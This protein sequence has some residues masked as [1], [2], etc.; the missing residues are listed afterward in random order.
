MIKK[1]IICSHR[2][3]NPPAIT[4]VRLLR[5]A[6][7]EN[8]QWRVAETAINAVAQQ[9]ATLRVSAVAGLLTIGL[10]A[11]PGIRL[12]LP[13]VHRPQAAMISQPEFVS[14]KSADR[15]PSLGDGFTTSAVRQRL[16]AGPE[17]DP[18]NEAP[19]VSRAPALIG[20]V[21]AATLR[22]D[23][24]LVR[25]AGLSLP[26]PGA[27]CKRL[28][29]LAVTCA[30]RA[31]GYLELLVKGRA[32]ACDHLGKAADGIDLSRCRIGETD[33]AEQMIRQG[34]ASA[35]HAEDARLTRAEAA[36]RQQNLG[37]WR[38]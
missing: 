31:T 10:F 16:R 21:D 30:E 27:M 6:F 17:T 23:D 32:V 11:G 8:G 4:G 25:V 24:R 28:D 37:I 13:D 12:A 14:A 5:R 1:I 29:G 35:A 20:V 19:V 36:A 9:K 2:L 7:I 26:A 34:W 18:I 38:K 3:F 22:T 33:I 15:V